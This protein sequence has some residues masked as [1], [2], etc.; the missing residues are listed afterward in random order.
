MIYWKPSKLYL[1]HLKKEKK[2][3][4]TDIQKKRKLHYFVNTKNKK[5]M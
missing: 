3:I 4:G 1:N 2:K 5:K